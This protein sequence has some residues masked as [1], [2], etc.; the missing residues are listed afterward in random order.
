MRSCCSSQKQNPFFSGNPQKPNNPFF[1]SESVDEMLW[2]VAL[3]IRGKLHAAEIELPAFRLI[4]RWIPQNLSYFKS[5]SNPSCH[6]NG[7]CR[8]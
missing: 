8:D 5:N 1:G 7:V 6:V 4:G 3:D 2:V